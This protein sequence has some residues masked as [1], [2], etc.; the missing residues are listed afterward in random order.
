MDRFK[1][2]A[3]LHYL[4][5]RQLLCKKRNTMIMMTMMVMKALLL[6]RNKQRKP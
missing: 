5:S 2:A 4:S 3:E 1:F 6:A